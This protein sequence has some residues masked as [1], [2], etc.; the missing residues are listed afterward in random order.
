MKNLFRKK[1]SEQ[2][3]VATKISSVVLGV[4]LAACAASV[5]AAIATG[6]NL[7]SRPLYIGAAVA[8]VVMLNVTK[9]H[10]LYY[11]A[12]NDYTDLDGDG[13]M[14][15]GYK[16]TIDYYGYFDPKKCYSYSA[17][18]GYF[19]PTRLADAEHYCTVDD[20]DWSGNFLNWISMSRIDVMR[21]VLY[22]GM[23]STDTANETV[24]E[25]A[26]VPADAHSWVKFYGDNDVSKLTPY[27]N[28]TPPSATSASNVTFGTSSSGR[29]FAGVNN[30]TLQAM[31]GDQIEAV[32]TADLALPLASRRF[33][34]G[35][36]IN[37]P[38]V[39]NNNAS[40][41]V[42]IV[43]GGVSAPGGVVTT[44]NA[45]GW[46]ITNKTYTGI[47]FC[48]VTVPADITAGNL[49]QDAA[50]TSRPPSIRVVRGDYS[51]WGASERM[52]CVYAEEKENTTNSLDDG[53][54]GNNDNKGNNGNNIGASKLDSAAKHPSTSR[55]LIS[56]GGV[57]GKPDYIA[58]V[59]VCVPGLIGSETCKNYDGGNVSNLKP[60][61]LLQKNGETDTPLM[62]FGLFTGTY[63]KNIS[64]G[65]LRK[66]ALASLSSTI[67][68]T[69]NEIDPTN[70][71]FVPPNVAK[72]NIGIIGTLNRLRMYNYKYTGG[73]GGDGYSD[74]DSCT[75][76]LL[77]M[78][79][80]PSGN[81]GVQG[82][83]AQ[84]GQCAS[85]G[86][87]MGEIYNETLRYLAGQT[88]ATATFKQNSSGK[89][90][91]LG[92]PMKTWI[93]P[94]ASTPALRAELY[95]TPLNILGINAS[96][97]SYD[98]NQYDGFLSPAVVNSFTDKVGEGE[99]VSGNSAVIGAAGGVSNG[100]CDAK[101]VADFSSVT[102]I[103]P[104]S[105][106][107]KGS[108]KM[109]GLAYYAHTNRIRTDITPPASDAKSLKVTTYGVQL[110]SST[111]VI[112][113]VVN[114][115]KIVITPAYSLARTEGFGS[116]TMVDFR[117]IGPISATAGTFYI[118]WEDSN[119]GGDYDQDVWGKLSYEVVGGQVKVT[120]QV[121]AHATDKPQGFGFTISGTTQDGPHFYS[122][123]KKFNYTDSTNLNVRMPGNVAATTAQNI[124]ASGGC[125]NCDDSL[126]SYTPARTVTFTPSAAG[127]AKTLK[128]PLFYA[129]KW[130]GFTGPNGA[131]DKPDVTS[132]WDALGSDGL[133]GT[134][135]LPDNYFYV[136]NPLKLE[137]SLQRAFLA[138]LRQGSSAAL[139][140]NSVSIS[141]G[142]RLYQAGFNSDRWIGWLRALPINS[143]G[144]V[145][146][147]AWNTDTTMTRA[148]VNH[149]TR[150]VFTFSGTAGKPFKWADLT[151]AQQLILNGSD[152]YGQD[153][154]NYLRGDGSLEVSRFRERASTLLGD[155]VNSSPMYVATPKGQYDYPQSLFSQLYSSD[156]TYATWRSESAQQNRTPMIYVGANDGMLHG[157][158]ATN[159]VEKLAYVPNAIYKRLPA[160][161]S[162]AYTHEFSVDGS[163]NVADVK[164]GNDWHTVLVAGLGAGGRGVY[165]LDVTNPDSF[166]V[167]N[168]LWEFTSAHDADLGYT[169][170][171]PIIA[172]MNN[173][174]WAAI[175]GN[176]YVGDNATYPSSGKAK[177]FIL[178]IENGMDG[179][180]V[181]DY[182]KIDTGAGTGAS[183]NG[184]GQIAA[185]DNNLDGMVDYIYGG[186]LQ[187]NLWKFDLSSASSSAW[188]VAYGTV[189]VPEPLVTVC[190]DRSTVA[191]CNN[192]RQPIV[193]RPSFTYHPEDLDTAIVYFGT[194]KYFEVNDA[195]NNDVQ[196]MYGAW[197][198]GAA[199]GSIAA[200]PASQKI[201]Q[202][203]VDSADFATRTVSNIPEDWSTHKLWM[204]DFPISGERHVGESRLLSGVL[205]YNTYI[206]SSARCEGGG[207]GYLMGVRY[208]NGGRLDFNLFDTDADNDVDSEDASTSGLRRSG[209]LGGPTFLR[210]QSVAPRV[211]DL[212]RSDITGNVTK[213]TAKDLSKGKRI[214]WRELLRN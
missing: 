29:T 145:G 19:S 87:P 62:R 188:K 202:T 115:K 103:C 92:L 101:G 213:D 209:S 189:A 95:C 55:G 147:A 185:R 169:F 154:V 83:L 46:T 15:T 119:Q 142:T 118:A 211:I 165:A 82:G 178:Y 17:A 173:G 120:T 28:V 5:G 212:Y 54:S 100:Y 138:I 107:Q 72:T 58:R 151:A 207:V 37:T 75:Y 3:M 150:P 34:K 167:S 33:L 65:V 214:G 193:T 122:G 1:F 196:S 90:S 68:T 127:G 141:T 49:S 61:G 56:V 208:Q 40:L 69:D 31:Q 44:G 36:V 14:D 10:Q 38:S 64:G 135:G 116:G 98:D 191:N 105:P 130:G 159:G 7:A 182:V 170:S 39:T 210:N 164:L 128:D 85:W 71:T 152:G 20:K 99:L 117:P 78:V 18:N 187:G 177:L 114:G 112:E 205:L 8:P 166:G 23:R 206:P 121:V 126:A 183:P 179:W 16:K 204:E 32:V 96:S 200:M 132:E 108:Y 143:N 2:T 59:K 12:Y 50:V 171:K 113:L 35:V 146:I 45:T 162:P 153:R 30:I 11:R 133:P 41:L 180:V 148:S 175:F 125:L 129:A 48:N 161:T 74:P 201:T 42:Q 52:Q 81:G 160:L 43:S 192:T 9:D 63:D 89:D 70:G 111:P 73:T 22:G 197:D 144:S 106:T 88:T 136:T 57:V 195:T 172:K 158:D 94:I 102:G 176:G 53:V 93:D 199:L 137:E 157:F 186:D 60:I 104:D 6:T 149:L 91:V 155:I 27:T 194:G 97:V 139:A 190:S 203:I 134:D 174:K 181:S 25:R 21:K 77:G 47:S 168:V 124:N 51:L 13:V 84:E 4:C 67:D 131:G 66:N 86:N 26:F 109:A 110:A 198:K 76:Q 123:I 80:A 163:P 156:S 140:T 184:L 24:L 79:H